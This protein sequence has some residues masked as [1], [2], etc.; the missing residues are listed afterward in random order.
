MIKVNRKI[1]N[2]R[3]Q[4]TPAY[5]KEARL[6][7]ENGYYDK[8][9]GL[10]EEASIDSH[11]SGCLLARNAGF[12]RKWRI[13]EYSPAPQDVLIRDFV[14]DVFTNLSHKELLED[15]FDARLKKYAV[16]DLTWEVID[17]RHVI[18]DFDPLHQRYFAYDVNG[19]GKLKLRGERDN[20][21]D[22]P[23]DSALV[24]TTK[25]RN[26]VL[27]PV[28]RDYILKDFGIEAWAG[29]LEKF[30]DPFILG[31]YPSGASREFRNELETG[32]NALASSARGTAPEGASI[33]IIETQRT[34]GD[35][36]AFTS[37]CK[38]GISIA[39]LGH[40]NAVEN[41]SGMQVGENLSAFEVKSEIA[42]DDIYFIE[43]FINRLIKKL[44]DRNF[45]TKSYPTF[46]IDKSKPL[47]F[48]QR[49]RV[50]DQAYEQ[51]Y[52]ID[53]EEYALLGLRMNDQQEPLRKQFP[54]TGLG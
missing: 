38:T 12:T 22:I 37:E 11:V 28:L 54:P 40:A 46:N 18:T 43:T 32:L 15:I 48:D 30:G 34:T 41:A 3:V 9:I 20:L 2:P 52:I 23:T 29:F 4:F 8:L 26:P 42:V 1:G 47:T 6:A 49:L 13:S 51:G 36:S 24:V 50:L 7:M 44:V 5:Y 25:N 14:N 45:T 10:M 17:N 35:H 27:L 53:P 39:L 33:E 21:I 19:D 31:K 16:I